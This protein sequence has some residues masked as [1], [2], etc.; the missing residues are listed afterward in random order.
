VTLTACAC[1]AVLVVKTAAR[2]AA[3]TSA[4]RKIPVRLDFML[5][6]FCLICNELTSRRSMF[7][8]GFLAVPRRTSL[9]SSSQGLFPPTRRSATPITPITGLV[10]LFQR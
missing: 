9:Y 2:E 10:F 7:R 5:N 8:S 3:I 6:P 4:I 1:A